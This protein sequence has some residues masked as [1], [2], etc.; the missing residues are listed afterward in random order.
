MEK[1]EKSIIKDALKYILDNFDDL[2]EFN[3][4]RDDLIKISNKV[5]KTSFD[6]IES[7]IERFNS[8][9]LNFANHKYKIKAELVGNNDIYSDLW[10]SLAMSINLLGEEL[11]YSTVTKNYLENVF[12]SISNLII[13]VDKHGIILQLNKA[14]FE[15][16]GYNK[17]F[18]VDRDLS[19]LVKDYNNL[20]IFDKWRVE[21]KPIQCELISSDNKIRTVNIT[22]SPFKR[23]DNE[24]IGYILFAQDISE[25]LEYQNKILSQNNKIKIALEKAQV[26]DR[27]KSSFLANIS[28][29]L[30]TPLNGILGFNSLILDE[31]FELEKRKEFSTIIASQGAHLLKLIEDLIDIS[32]IE[33]DNIKIVYN[34][35]NLNNFLGDLKNYYENELIVNCKKNIEIVLKKPSDGN[36]YILDSDEVRLKQIFNNLFYNAMKFTESGTIEIGYSYIDIGYLFYVSDTG[37]GIPSEYRSMIFEPFRQVDESSKRVHGG[38]GLGLTIVKK[39][40]EALGGQIWVESEFG[41]GTQVNFTVIAK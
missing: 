31:S 21:N 36:D 9:L 7:K 17:E 1:P 18:L 24:V 15:T 27:L 20:N 28:H 33:S 32:L 38:M 23:G 4:I 30:R 41:K 2:N 19:C 3:D 10:D 11:N 26:S 37:I 29:E 12:D 14:V 8:A 6:G 22:I 13:I 5:N 40:I 39:L 34:K 35:I 25:I 16:T